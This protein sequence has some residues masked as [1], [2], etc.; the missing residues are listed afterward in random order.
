LLGNG[1]VNKFR[2]RQILD[3]QLVAAKMRGVFYVVHAESI[4]AAVF[5]DIEKLFDTTWH[6][7]LLYKLSKLEFST[8]LITLIQRKFNVSVEGEISTPREMR[9][10]APQG[11]VL[12]PTFYYFFIIGGVGL[13]P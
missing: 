5:S 9:A 7:G 10:G 6:S 4:T 13:I 8:S 2:R 3:K 11:S 12:S 1:S